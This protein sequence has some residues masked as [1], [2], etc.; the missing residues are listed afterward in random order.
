MGGVPRDSRPDSTLALLSEGYRFIGNGCARHRSDVFETRLLFRSTLCMS[1]AEAARMFY[2]SEHF[3]R[4]GAVPLR[5]RKTLFGMGGVQELD[6]EAHRSRKAMFMSLMSSDGI[7]RLCEQAEKHWRASIREWAR[8]G[9]LVLLDEVQQLLCRVVC[10]WTGVPLPEA[11]VVQRTRE[12]TAL[13]DGA[14]GV[15][16]RHWRARLMRMRSEVWL[17]RL[18]TRVRAGR[19]AAAEGSALRTVAEYRGPDGKRL[20][21]RLAAVELLNVLRPIVA[22]ARFVVF[23][24]LAL[25][26][27]PE[28]RARLLEED[29]DEA[30]E[31]F[32]Q[33][34]RRSY[35]FM[36]F[37]VARVRRD[38][39]WKGYHFPRGRRVLLDLYGTNHDARLWER[40]HEFRP[41][42]FR[43][44]DGSPFS[45]IPQGG[46]DHHTGHRCAGEWS[47]IALMK[48][49][50]R[51]LTRGMRYDVPP[52][53]LRVSLSRIPAEPASRFVIANVRAVEEMME[54]AGDSRAPMP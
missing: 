17:G 16:P 1:G 42:R 50:A 4:R 48:V 20:G 53:D 9:R 29:D 23:E 28:S 35:P 36:P 52:Q 6:G 3:Q 18:V 38:F 51:M 49:A 30:Y 40:P 27:H 46:G 44:W 8:K 11:E 13:L 41:E 45:F 10:E 39:T 34:V 43:T 25:H 14:G 37:V 15:G 22:V 12:L 2:D 54:R 19:H 24:A 21:P 32:V 7:R 47:T 31:H 26:E 33:E 5:L